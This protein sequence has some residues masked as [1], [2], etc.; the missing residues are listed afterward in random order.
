MPGASRGTHTRVPGRTEEEPAKVSS[1]TSAPSP[2]PWTAAR[3]I[4]PMISPSTQSTG[5]RVANGAPTNAPPTAILVLPCF[6]FPC[7]DTGAPGDTV[8]RSCFSARW[9]PSLRP[10]RLS[11]TRRRA[12][13]AST[14]SVSRRAHLSSSDN[15]RRAARGSWG[16]C[17]ARPPGGAGRSGPQDRIRSHRGD[18]IVATTNGGK[19]WK[20]QHV[21]GGTTP[22]LSG[23]S[24]PTATDCMAIGSTGASLPGSAVVVTTSDAGTMWTPTTAPMALSR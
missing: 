18:L 7:L 16:P 1:C 24:C 4:S 22:Q 3:S 20:A 5:A 23:V 14:S 12:P 2:R 15:R 13:G 21:A 6:H 11:G 19:S 17:R 10:V 9:R 8:A